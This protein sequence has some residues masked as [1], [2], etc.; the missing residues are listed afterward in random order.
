MPE[1][2]PR[3]KKEAVLG[4]GGQI[5]ECLPTLEA[6]EQTSK[7]IMERT[8][9]TFI[10]PSNDMDVILG[11]ATAAI[12]LIE[13]HPELDRIVSPVGGGGLIAGTALA[14]NTFPDSCITLGGEPL[15]ADD[16]YRSMISGKIETN[17]DPQTIADGLKT[18]LGHINFPI[19]Q[20]YVSRIT[21]VTETEIK[22]AMR[23]LWERMKIIVEPSSAVALAAI[24]KETDAIK[25][26]K[27]GII[28]SGGNVDLGKLPF[29]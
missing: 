3:V 18:Q 5:T 14:V 26:K 4:Y 24:L 6:R 11:N 15:N 9:A 28:L 13:L 22:N 1:T 2:A 10:H 16:A 19:I 8:G 12:E 27:V 20:Q 7:T 25:G 21:R 23:L 29:H 17:T